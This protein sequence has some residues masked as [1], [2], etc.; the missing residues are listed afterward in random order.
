[1]ENERERD[2]KNQAF[3]S[4]A[5]YYLVKEGKEGLEEEEIGLGHRKFDMPNAC[6]STDSQ[7]SGW[8]LNSS[9][10]RLETHN[11]MSSQI[12]KNQMLYLYEKMKI[13]N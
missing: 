11:W 5:A 10:Q 8:L 2:I 9:V 4:E 1:M 6:A 13:E 12:T 3:P 7:V